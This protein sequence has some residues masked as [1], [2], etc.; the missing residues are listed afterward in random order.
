MRNAAGDENE[1]KNRIGDSRVEENDNN[2]LVNRSHQVHSGSWTGCLSS[3]FPP[4][5]IRSGS[6]GFQKR[7][8]QSAMGIM[9]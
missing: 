1:A 5:L 8:L 7:K 2:S 6:L 3:A 4:F 9:Y